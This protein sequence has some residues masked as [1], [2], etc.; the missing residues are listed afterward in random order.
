MRQLSR[1]ILSKGYPFPVDGLVGYWKFDEESG[2]TAVDS[3][4]NNDGVASN[5]RVLTGGAKG[6]IGRAADFTQ[7]DDHIDLGDNVVLGSDFSV[8]GWV[9]VNDFD[10]VARNYYHIIAKGDIVEANSWCLVFRDERSFDGTVVISFRINNTTSTDLLVYN[11]LDYDDDFK[12]NTWYHI[13]YV[14]N[15][16]SAKIYFNGVELTT[17]LGGSITTPND[18]PNTVRI[19]NSSQSFSTSQPLN[20]LIDEFGIWNRALTEQEVKTLYNASKGKPYIK[21]VWDGLISYYNFNEESG[22]DVNDS[23]G[24]NDGVASNTDVLDYSGKKG[25]SVYFGNGS[26]REVNYGNVFNFNRLDA[27]SFNLWIKRD[28]DNTSVQSIFSKSL[29]SQPFTGYDCIILNE[30]LRIQLVNT[31]SGNFIQ[32]VSNDNVFDDWEW[33]LLTITY[34]GSSDA[35]G[36][37][38]YDNGNPLS[39]TVNANS[40]TNSITTTIPFRVGNRNTETQSLKGYIDETA[41]WNRALS[42]DEVSTLYN[43]GAGKFY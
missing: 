42:A 8:G 2:T 25:R 1:N 22:T 36:L 41:I 11:A 29:V 20:G 37:K 7:G 24:G 15:S 30:K 40:L 19:G 9:N 38:V 13:L 16:N 26:D 14:Q 43:N 39:M 17:T 5:T 12:F 10:K 35:S 6:R 32:L 18:N 3:Y 27:F 4:G 23:K 33:H 34:D 28:N 21:H 31:T